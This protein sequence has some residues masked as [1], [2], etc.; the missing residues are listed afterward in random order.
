MT[1]AQAQ[2]VHDFILAERDSR[3]SR[4][5]TGSVLRAAQEAEY[6]LTA[7]EAILHEAEADAEEAADREQEFRAEQ[8]EAMHPEVRCPVRE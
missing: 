2:T 5:V 3:K 4:G 8:Y 6:A 1:L 7:A